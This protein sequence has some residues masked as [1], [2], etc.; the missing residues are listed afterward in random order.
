MR[1]ILAIVLVL[2]ASPAHSQG[3]LCGKREQVVAQLQSAHGEVRMSVG[4]QRNARIM[5]TYANIETGTWTIIAST[6]AGVSCLIAAGQSFQSETP[7]E[8]E[9][10][11]G[12]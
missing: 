2:M 6:P 5:E 4:L 8:I 3:G 11:E 7:G 12:S 1:F 9:E 10:G